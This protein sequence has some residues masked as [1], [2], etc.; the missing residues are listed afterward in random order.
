MSLSNI[1]KSAQYVPVEQIMMLESIRKQ[2]E[3]MLTEKAAVVE[4]VDE[5]MTVERLLAK[6]KELSQLRDS[7]LS[8]AKNFAEEE[9][10]SATQEAERM[11]EEARST[12]DNWWSE[13]R[14]D[15]E[16]LRE[17]LR[18]EAYNQ[19]YQEGI[20][21]AEE[22]I[23]AAYEIK[24]SESAE[25]LQQAY[26]AKEQIIQEAEP[27]VVSLSS[28]IAEKIIDHQLSLDSDLV[29]SMI[30]KQLSRKK[31]SGQITLCVS[32]HQ[33]SFIHAAR[34]ELSLAI[35]S[36]AELI[37]VPDATVKD[38][39]CVIR[40]SLG[41]ID[42]RINTQLEELKKALQQIAMQ[43]EEQDANES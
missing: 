21:Q 12:I 32:P 5:V 16:H 19:G 4:P 31:E 30:H 39:G 22:E 13:R 11:L 18:Q 36:Q 8:D 14:S 7:I 41:S 33:F 20:K 29:L 42:A 17:T 43:H 35:D 28:A 38:Y 27:F 26:L 15:D 24:I 9:V 25:I 23:Q 34:E 6:D 10:R 37:I 2:R 3:E 40:S 1:I